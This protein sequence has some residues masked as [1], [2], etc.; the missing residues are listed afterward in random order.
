LYENTQ[1]KVM[2]DLYPSLSAQIVKQTKLN[3]SE[4]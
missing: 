2:A 3:T 4:N 1:R